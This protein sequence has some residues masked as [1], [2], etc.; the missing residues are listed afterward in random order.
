MASSNT[1]HKHQNNS[2]HLD[3][4]RY[5]FG[6]IT[7]QGFVIGEV[8]VEEKRRRR[9]NCVYDCGFTISNSQVYF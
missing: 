6:L 2:Q 8:G 9:R 1:S 3:W 5:V 7:S 4:V